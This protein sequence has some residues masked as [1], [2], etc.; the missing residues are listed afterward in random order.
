M[1]NNHDARAKMADLESTTAAHATIRQFEHI[2]KLH[3]SPENRF[4]FHV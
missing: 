1:L 2:D 4:G 3:S